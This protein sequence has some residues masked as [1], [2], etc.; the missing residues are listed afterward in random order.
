MRCT[1]FLPIQVT[2][3]ERKLRGGDG[4]LEIFPAAAVAEDFRNQLAQPRC[5]MKVTAQFT[6][7]KR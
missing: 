1:Y 5:I 4:S 7:N 3:I 6:Q 2:K